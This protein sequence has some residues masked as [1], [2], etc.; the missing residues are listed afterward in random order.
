MRDTVHQTPNSYSD[1]AQEG[2]RR[3]ER[4]LSLHDAGDICIGEDRPEDLYLV[5]TRARW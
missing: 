5:E 4:Q 1:F 2:A 3:P